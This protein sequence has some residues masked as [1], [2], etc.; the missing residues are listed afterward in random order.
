MTLLIYWVGP[1]NENVDKTIIFFKR[2]K[3]KIIEGY[4]HESHKFLL[5]NNKRYKY[6][7]ENKQYAFCADIWRFYMLSK[8]NDAVYIDANIVVNDINFLGDFKKT[9]L[10]K[11]NKD[12]YISSLMFNH[13]NME[14]FGKAFD[15]VCRGYLSPA[16]ISK[17][18][19]K[20]KYF[21][22]SW[23]DSK[24]IE[25]IS[26]FE[27][28]KSVELISL[29]SWRRKVKAENNWELKIAESKNE[30]YNTFS[31]K[32]IFAIFSWFPKI[33]GKIITK[34]K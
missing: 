6:Y 3:F 34:H 33:V 1:Y 31:R 20:Y 21:K 13:N 14:M 7:F 2:K 18:T 27:L 22:N 23:S 17:V 8:I 26:L 25:S 19:R 30:K 24:I 10:V 12:F 11:E 16:A 4:K 5:K 15:L 29:A 28:S 9:F 32:I